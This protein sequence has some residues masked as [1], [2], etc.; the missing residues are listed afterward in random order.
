MDA[1]PSYFLQ[2]YPVRRFSAQK[3]AAQMFLCQ[4]FQAM[5]YSVLME[6]HHLIIGDLSR[7][8]HILF[9]KYNTPAAHILPRI[10]FLQKPWLTK[11]FALFPLLI[12]GIAAFLIGVSSSWH[13][14]AASFCFLLFLL[15]GCFSNP[16]NDNESSGLLACYLF[17]KQHPKDVAFVLLDASPFHLG[18]RAFFRSY[19]NQIKDKR[20]IFIAPCGMGTYILCTGDLS[21]PAY[22]SERANVI[23]QKKKH[24]IYHCII[25]CGYPSLYGIT[26]SNPGTPKDNRL[27]ADL[28]ETVAAFL[29]KLIEKE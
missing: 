29:Q 6:G 19:R 17:A 23:V 1:W 11:L 2:Q 26:L 7:C 25:Q 16:N 27:D 5:G 15:Y 14:G 4:T 22:Q 9:A 8:K 10:L 20:R 24:S 13:F 3:Q 21:L 18:Q 28:L 12:L